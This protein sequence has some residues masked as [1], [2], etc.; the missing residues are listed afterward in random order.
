MFIIGRIFIMNESGKASRAI[1]VVPVI[2]VLGMYMMPVLFCIICNMQESTDSFDAGWIMVMPIVLGLV[3]LAVLLILGKR[4]SRVQLLICTRIIKYALIPFYVVGG[5]CIIV[6]LLLM[7]T[8][9]V[10]MIFV[11]PTVAIVLSVIGWLG[12]L[13][14][15]PFSIAYIIRACSEGV[16]GKVLSVF[17]GIFQ[18]FFTL[19]VI[20]MIILAVKDRSFV[21]AQKG[22]GVIQ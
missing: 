14:A 17:A 16:Q 18:F 8:P 5:F 13:G 10:I 15:A 2:Y 12:L 22:Y 1:Y 11:G 3:N 19:D 6:A 20:F 21:K 7:L 9:V 4:I